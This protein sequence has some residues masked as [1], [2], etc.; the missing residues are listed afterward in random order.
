MGLQ[1]T[2]SFKVQ[3]REAKKVRSDFFLATYRRHYNSSIKVGQNNPMNDIYQIT[4]IV[5]TF[6]QH[7]QVS[8]YLLPNRS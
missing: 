7:F 3:K 6:A 5:K 1:K 2:E 8:V 4:Y